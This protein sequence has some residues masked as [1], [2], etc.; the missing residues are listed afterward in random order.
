MTSH[1]RGVTTISIAH[2][3]STIQGASN[4]IVFQNGCVMEQGNHA[5]L[6]ALPEGHYS[7]LISSQQST[8]GASGAAGTRQ[9]MSTRGSS[10]ALAG[11]PSLI[12]APGA[13]SESKL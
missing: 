10:N 6:C 13:G 4:I 12:S 3:L 11:T 2:R 8:A 5:A 9:G 7:K 1:M